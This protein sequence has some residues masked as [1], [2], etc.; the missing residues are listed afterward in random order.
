MFTRQPSLLRPH[1]PHTSCATAAPLL[2]MYPDVS[3]HPWPPCCPAACRTPAAPQQP[4]CC[5]CIL[6][7]PPTPGVTNPASGTNS[8]CIHAKSAARI[9][10]AGTKAGKGRAAAPTA[11]EPCRCTAATA[12]RRAVHAFAC[13]V[14]GRLRADSCS[15]APSDN[16]HH[17][18]RCS[19]SCGNTAR[20]KLRVQQQ[21]KLGTRGPPEVYMHSN[22]PAECCQPTS[23][24]GTTCQSQTSFG[25]GC[26]S[27][28]G[29]KSKT[30]VEQQEHAARSQHPPLWAPSG[31]PQ[32][33][34]SRRPQR[35]AAQR[36]VCA[37]HPSRGW[38]ERTGT[39]TA[40]RTG[41]CTA[42]RADTLLLR[43]PAAAAAAAAHA[44]AAEF[45]HR[46][47]HSRRRRKS[48]H[49]AV[50]RLQPGL[51]L[52]G[53]EGGPVGG[54]L[55][56]D[57][58]WS[59]RDAPTRALDGRVPCR[60]AATA[61]HQTASKGRQ[62]RSSSPSFHPRRFAMLLKVNGSQACHFFFVVLPVVLANPP[63]TKIESVVCHVACKRTG[64]CGQPEC[65]VQEGRAPPRSSG[66]HRRC[67]QQCAH[68]ATLA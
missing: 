4:L 49:R 36:W 30:K 21:R 20:R 55:D 19:A 5:L 34:P 22:V 48:W 10:K 8:P 3:T 52:G 65:D 54:V 28:A 57:V 56:G 46:Q 66:A 67:R 6:M 23:C 31:C 35:P 9:G 41:T 7:Y 33:P 13:H 11:D 51:P 60:A 38:R 61:A 14:Q 37:R 25:E 1:V 58:P 12:A 44:S 50:L 40:V 45:A 42:A 63:A 26:P 68:Q 32:R 2:S 24:G 43:S 27:C 62:Q 29:P 64:R 47:G 16:C 15:S 53:L 59:S 39:C 17:S 18:P